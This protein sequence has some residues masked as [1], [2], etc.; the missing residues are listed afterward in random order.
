[1][2]RRET[3]LALRRNRG[4]RFRGRMTADAAH[5]LNCRAEAICLL[6]LEETDTRVKSQETRPGRYSVRMK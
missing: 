4:R 6:P 5:A 1:M 2:V 3:K